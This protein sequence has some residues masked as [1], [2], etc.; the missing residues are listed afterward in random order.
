MN[1]TSEQLSQTFDILKDT[2][3]QILEIVPKDLP[4]YERL[5]VFQKRLSYLVAEGV[6][7]YWISLI[8]VLALF[9]T[10]EMMET[11]DWAKKVGDIAVDGT[12]RCADILGHSEHK[13]QR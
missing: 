10:D 6:A 1:Y 7:D 12:N 9:I 2:V 5:E 4:I 13:I 3:K 8:D 11:V